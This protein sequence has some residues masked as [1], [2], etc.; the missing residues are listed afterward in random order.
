MI[1]PVVLAGGSGSRLLPLSQ[2]L[3][4]KQ[5]FAAVWRSNI[6]TADYGEF[7]RPQCNGAVNYL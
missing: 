6:V 7:E 5:L 2:Q 3:N 1:K 4:P